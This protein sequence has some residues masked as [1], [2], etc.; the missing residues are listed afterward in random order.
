MGTVSHYRSYHDEAGALGRVVQACVESL[1]ACLESEREDAILRER[2]LEAI[3]AVYRFDVNHGGFGLT[4]DIPP[5]FLQ[6][7][8]PEEKH[9]IAQWVRTALAELQEKKS[10]RDWHRKRFGGLL[11]ALE[12]DLL[13][14]EDFLSFGR[15]TKSMQEVVTRLIEVVAVYEPFKNARQPIC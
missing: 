12:A 15:E 1:G 11:L 6:G 4:K 10:E 7:T 9:L 8:T 2:I 3:F 5:E 14:E 13:N